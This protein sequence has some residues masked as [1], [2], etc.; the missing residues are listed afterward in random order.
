MGLP[1][2]VSRAAERMGHGQRGAG[3]VAAGIYVLSVLAIIIAFA[4][5]FLAAGH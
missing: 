2:I 1:K 4:I 5:F 3:N